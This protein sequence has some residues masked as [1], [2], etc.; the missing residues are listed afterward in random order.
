MRSAPGRPLSAFS[1]RVGATTLLLVG[2]GPEVG[3][4]TGLT[5]DDDGRVVV[6]HVVA[7]AT[8]GGDHPWQQVG[9]QGDQVAALEAYRS[10]HR[11][12]SRAIAFTGTELEALREVRSGGNA[13]SGRRTGS[14]RQ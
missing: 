6:L 1:A 13:A 11:W 8:D 9:V 2:C 4:V 5:V 3:T 12:T 14:R 10:D 7:L